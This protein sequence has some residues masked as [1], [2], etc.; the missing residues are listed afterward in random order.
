MVHLL[1]QTLLEVKVKKKN[2]KCN[3]CFVCFRS[4]KRKL[5]LST[6]GGRQVTKAY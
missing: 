5:H 1:M 6:S 2:K 4:L 3:V